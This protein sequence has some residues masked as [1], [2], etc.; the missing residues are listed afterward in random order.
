MTLGEDGRAT[1]DGA[2]GRR[3][4]LTDDTTGDGATDGAPIWE[5]KPHSGQLNIFQKKQ[6]G[7]CY[8]M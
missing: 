6:K 3:R 5:G 8:I 1:Y 7:R 2:D 4:R